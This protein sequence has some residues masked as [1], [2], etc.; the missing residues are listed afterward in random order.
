MFIGS[1]AA[2]AAAA[3]WEQFR[4][5]EAERF[6]ARGREYTEGYLSAFGPVSKLWSRIVGNG[7][8]YGALDA[9]KVLEGK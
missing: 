6:I 2:V 5:E 7:T 1:G 3:G 4:R 9:K 8:Y